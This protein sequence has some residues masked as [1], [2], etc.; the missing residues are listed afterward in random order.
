MTK[1]KFTIEDIEVL[2]GRRGGRLGRARSR[3]IP[4]KHRVQVRVPGGYVVALGSTRAEAVRS[5]LTILGVTPERWRRAKKKY[6]EQERSRRLREES[7]KIK[8]L[9]ARRRYY[10]AE[11]RRIDKKIA[12]GVK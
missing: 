8:R 4:V 10:A 1:T 7:A 11:L 2:P 6:V 12:K 9:H 3:R 5:C